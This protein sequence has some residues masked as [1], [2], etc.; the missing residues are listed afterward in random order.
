MAGK[1]RGGVVINNGAAGLPTFEGQQFGVLTRIA[2]TPE[3]DAIYRAEYKGLYIEA[4][5][6]RYDQAAYVEWFDR[7]WKHNSPAEVSYRNRILNGPTCTIGNALLADSWFYPRTGKRHIRR[8]NRRHPR[9]WKMR[10]RGLC[11]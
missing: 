11:I 6:V 2:A 7:L 4:V 9:I 3:E 10:W 1:L 5:P 8:E